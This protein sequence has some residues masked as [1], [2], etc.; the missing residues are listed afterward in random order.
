M[1][2][3]NAYFLTGHFVR[4]KLKRPAIDR[5]RPENVRCPDV[6]LFPV[7]VGRCC[8][9]SA[10]GCCRP[11]NSINQ[12]QNY[13][14]MLSLCLE[15]QRS[16]CSASSLLTSRW[17]YFI[18]FFWILAFTVHDVTD[19]APQFTADMLAKDCEVVYVVS[20]TLVH[21]AGTTCSGICADIRTG[22]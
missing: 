4:F 10:H 12:K 22:A 3:S 21:D 2:Q 15:F 9:G 20:R 16:K 1:R 8:L 14:Y 13:E 18:P 7:L 6:I 11:Q 17:C 19:I 5:K